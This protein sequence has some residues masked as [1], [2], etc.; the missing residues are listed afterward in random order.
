M[1]LQNGTITDPLWHYYFGSIAVDAAGNVGLGFSGSHAGVY[2]STFVT[3]RHTT[4]PSGTNAAPIMTKA[5]EGAINH[6]DGSGR[7]RFGDYS[8]INVDPVDDLGFWT[9]QRWRHEQQ[10]EDLDR[11]FR[12]RDR[13]YG[14]GPRARPACRRR[15]DRASEDHLRSRCGWATRR[16]QPRARSSIGVA[17][18]NTPILGGT[19]LVSPFITEGS[20]ADAVGHAR[21]PHPNSPALVGRSTTDR[22]DRR[23]AAQGLSFSRGLCRRSADRPT[24]AR[25]AQA[26]DVTS[27]TGGEPEPARPVERIEPAATRRPSAAAHD[28]GRPR[29][30]AGRRVRRAATTNTNA[31]RRPRTPRATE[32]RLC[33]EGVGEKP[34]GRPARRAP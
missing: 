34:S 6:L 29:P 26:H 17:T 3:G 20:A 30:N 25:A 1:L 8:H 11:A 28:N 19:M 27:A 21:H 13:F 23:G 5:G 18:A 22:A 16:A 4:D 2:A 31:R 32:P 24:A 33:G 9:I 14:D 15:D 12:L 7:N 10:L